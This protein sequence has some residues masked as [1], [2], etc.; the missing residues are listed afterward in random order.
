MVS[1]PPGSLVQRARWYTALGLAAVVLSPAPA[2][3]R[4]I[5]QDDTPPLVSYTVDGIVGSNGWYRGSS[6]GAFIVVHWS[7]SDPD[8]PITSTT[9]CEPAV[10][11][12]DPNTGTTLTCTASS[13]GGTTSVTTKT[14]K[15]D[16]T[17]PTSVSASAARSPDHSGWFNASLGIG[18]S[19]SDATSGIASCS[20]ITYSG[21]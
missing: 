20:S 6:S 17:A 5:L 1:S 4:H 8:S 15:V 21:P 16:A 7:V 13:D 3:A 19:G 10:R 9:G 14:L 18:W 2:E 12:N 11:V